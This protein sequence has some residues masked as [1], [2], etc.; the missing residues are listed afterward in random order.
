MID[1][2]FGTYVKS[3]RALSPLLFFFIEY[4]C[5][6]VQHI[7]KSFVLLI[8]LLNSPQIQWKKYINYISYIKIVT[9][10][11]IFDSLK[12]GIWLRGDKNTVLSEYKKESFNMFEGLIA[13]IE[14]TIANRIFRV[15]PS[16]QRPVRVMPKNIVTKK[17]NI[18]ITLPLEDK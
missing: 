9:P 5:L 15:Q 16:T 6:V 3:L 2:I 13:T 12:E 11:H 17:E 10:S 4:L 7:K 1:L 18:R 14:S 8:Y